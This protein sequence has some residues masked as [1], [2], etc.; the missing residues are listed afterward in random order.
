MRDLWAIFFD[1]IKTVCSNKH[2]SMCILTFEEITMRNVARWTFFFSL[3][4]TVV[5]VQFVPSAQISAQ[6]V[7]PVSTPTVAVGEVIAKSEDCVIY[8]AQVLPRSWKTSR[9]LIWAE[10]RHGASCSL[11]TEK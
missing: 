11:N 2:S 9:M 10:G 6:T 5:V 8:A 3:L 4:A 7:A 1:K